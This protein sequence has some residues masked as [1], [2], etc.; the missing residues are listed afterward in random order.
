MKAFKEYAIKS[1]EEL[2]PEMQ[3]RLMQAFEDYIAKKEK[4]KKMKK[5]LLQGLEEYVTKPPPQ[6]NVRLLLVLEE[7]AKKSKVRPSQ[8]FEIYA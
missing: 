1:R 3:E 8:W 4:K 5:R 7:Y 2:I 6:P